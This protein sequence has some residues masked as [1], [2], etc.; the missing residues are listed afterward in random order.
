MCVTSMPTINRSADWNSL[1]PTVGC[2]YRLVPLWPSTKLLKNLT[3]R[4]SK[5]ASLSAMISRTPA[6]L[7]PLFSAIFSGAPC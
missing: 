2:T 3:Y 1:N 5:S 4:S 6:V 7:A